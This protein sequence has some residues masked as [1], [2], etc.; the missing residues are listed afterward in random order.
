MIEII[1]PVP[2]SVNRYWRSGVVNGHAQI[3]LS[4]EAKAYKQEVKLLTRHLEPFTG[5]V[6]VNLTVFRPRKKGDCDNYLKALLDAIKGSVYID[7][8][9]VVEIHA[10]RDDDKRDPRVTLLVREVT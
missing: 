1:L 8:D 3:Y 10:Y 7:D 6:V 5:L 9:Q 4:D 2:P